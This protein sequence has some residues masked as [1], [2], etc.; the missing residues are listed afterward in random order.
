MYVCK[1]WLDLRLLGE[2]NSLKGKRQVICSLKSQLKNKFGISIA[3]VGSNHLWQRTEFGIAF[4]TADRVTAEQVF[5]KIIRFIDSIS[6]VE[7]IEIF[8]DVEK[9]K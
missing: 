3:E 6:E 2:P 1:C 9:L 4:V 5:E 8:H 7:I